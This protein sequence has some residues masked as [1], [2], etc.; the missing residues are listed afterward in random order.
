[1]NDQ[2]QY[3]Y[4]LVTRNKM[5]LGQILY[6][7]QHEK[8]TLYR[9]FFEKEQRNIQGEDAFQ[10]LRNG[11]SET[12]LQLSKEDAEV[13]LSYMGSSVRGIREMIVEMVR[14]QE[15]PHYP[16]RLACLYVTKG[17]EDLLK[18]KKLFESYNRKILQIVKLRVDGNY[19]EGD[20]EQLPK[21]D[22]TSFAK[23][24]EQARNY[25]LNH[26]NADL[27]EMLVDGIIEVV[28]II[29]EFE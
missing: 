24:I 28:E 25:W 29:E 9:F 2:E 8:N 16:S 22:G 20:G 1:M 14:L 17:Y 23:K 21:E 3:V 15:F 27:A 6:F 5:Q 19:F 18:W 12:G 7:G 10:I 13:V 11:H 4:H 26:D